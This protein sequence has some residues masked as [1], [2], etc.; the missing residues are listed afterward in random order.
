MLAGI[1]E[2]KH[3]FK[4]L[5]EVNNKLKRL[6]RLHPKVWWMSHRNW[7]VEDLKRVLGIE[8]QRIWTS[9]CQKKERMLRN[10][11]V[12]IVKEKGLSFLGLFSYAGTEDLQRIENNMRK[13]HYFIS[14]IFYIH[15]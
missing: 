5:N 6:T 10:D 3:I 12:P 4:R 15:A 1:S 14:K 7:L 9:F 11:I 13:E 2:V 8:I